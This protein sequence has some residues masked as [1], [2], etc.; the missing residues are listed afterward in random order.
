MIDAQEKEMLRKMQAD[1]VSAKEATAMIAQRRKDKEKE[2]DKDKDKKDD[3]KDGDK[4]KDQFNKAYESGNLLQK[5]AYN[6][7]AL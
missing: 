7:L 4:D 5:G 6:F 1:N 2:Q 3:K